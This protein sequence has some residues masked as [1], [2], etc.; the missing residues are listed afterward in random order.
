MICS[1]YLVT[2]SLLAKS[3]YFR[4]TREVI[5]FFFNIDY[6]L[7]IIISTQIVTFN[8]KFDYDRGFL[9]DYLSF[10]QGQLIGQLSKG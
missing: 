8:K 4:K 7:N 5:C 9:G 3:R 2:T 10:T 6:F 1:K